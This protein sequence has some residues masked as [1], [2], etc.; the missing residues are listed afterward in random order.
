M[1]G[2]FCLALCE[3][4]LFMRDYIM[5]WQTPAL[6]PKFGPW[7]VPVACELRMEFTFFNFG[8]AAGGRGR[9][10]KEELDFVM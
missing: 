1:P 3:L 6:P 5:L 2:L 8:A 9:G 4:K 10:S 7:S